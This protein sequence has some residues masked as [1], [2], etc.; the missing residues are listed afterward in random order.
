MTD[1]V[2]AHL[3]L[4]ECTFKCTFTRQLLCRSFG[5]QLDSLVLRCSLERGTGSLHPAPPFS[6]GAGG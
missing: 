2:R 4:L 1:E 5:Q 3:P 6:G